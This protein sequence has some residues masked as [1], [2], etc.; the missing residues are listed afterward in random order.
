MAWLN[1]LDAKWKS[2]DAAWEA[3]LER[4]L[5]PLFDLLLASLPVVMLI[6]VIALGLLLAG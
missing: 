6:V 4:H 3:R 5:S 2:S 1:R